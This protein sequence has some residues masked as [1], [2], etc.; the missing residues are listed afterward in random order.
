[1]ANEISERFEVVGVLFEGKQPSRHA[2]MKLGSPSGA[3]EIEMTEYFGQFAFREEVWLAEKGDKFKY[4][5]N[6]NCYNIQPDSLNG[7]EVLNIIQDLKPDCIAVFGTSLIRSTLLRVCPHFINL[8]LGLSP[9]YRGVGCSFWPFYNNEP[10]YVGSTVM[11]MDEGIDSGP[12]IHQ[13]VV[14][15]EPGDCLHDG[16][17]KA[18]VSGVGLQVRALQELEEGTLELFPQDLNMGRV[19]YNRHFN[20]EAL[21]KGLQNWERRFEDYLKEQEG[22]LDAVQYIP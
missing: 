16:S 3:G 12:I 9:F 19:Y 20:P 22:R 14:R 11:G 5:K 18:V 21:R 10:E 2:A 8:H 7:S 13:S 1:M 6:V 4:S 15:F 17:L